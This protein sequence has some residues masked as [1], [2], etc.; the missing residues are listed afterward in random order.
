MPADDHEEKDTFND[1]ND[2]QKSISEISLDK[3]RLSDSG[4][5]VK[6]VPVKDVKSFL[7]SSFKASNTDHLPVE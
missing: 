5:K 3:A 1:A 2:A 7:E 4:A 6:P